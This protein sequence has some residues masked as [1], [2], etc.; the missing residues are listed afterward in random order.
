[1]NQ[2]L[3]K[4]YENKLIDEKEKINDILLKM[5][6]NDLIYRNEEI[7]SEISH[8]DN[9]PADSAGNIV[10]MELGIALKSNEDKILYKIEKALASIKD[11]S[12]GICK[13]C[14]KEITKERLDVIPYAE[15]CISCQ[16]RK[17]SSVRQQERPVE[18][19]VLG[20]PFIINDNRILTDGSDCYQGVYDYN[21]I[22]NIEDFYNE[23]ED[24]FYTDP[25]DKISNAQYKAGLPD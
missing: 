14:G 13:S 15:Y 11:G 19:K 2:K 6:K 17:N 3:M 9:H 23:D 5:K 1:M 8:Y 10:D 16:K 4:C 18:E 7:A 12:Y 22:R 24:E 21:D 20:N 25:M